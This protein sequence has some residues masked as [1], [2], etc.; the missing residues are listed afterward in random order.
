MFIVFEGQEAIVMK[1][2]A[3]K[4]SKRIKI[5]IVIA[6]VLLFFGI[7]YFC[8]YHSV[9]FHKITLKS[10]N[11][12]YSYQND[13]VNTGSNLVQI[14]DKLYYNYMNENILKSGLYEIS[15]DVTKRIDWGGISLLPAYATSV[16]T[17]YNGIILDDVLYSTESY[18]DDSDDNPFLYNYEVLCGDLIIK[19][20]D[21]ERNSFSDYLTIKN[22]DKIKLYQ[23]FSIVDDTIYLYSIDN[24]IYRYENNSLKKV[25]DAQ[26][27]NFHSVLMSYSSYINKNMIYYPNQ[28]N[29]IMSICR[30]DMN[31]QKVVDEFTIG[32]LPDCEDEIYNLIATNTYIY[33]TSGN[34]S[35][36]YR[37]NL[38][39]KKIEKIFNTDG[40]VTVNIIDNQPVLAVEKSNKDNG[41]YVVNSETSEFERICK[42]EAC[43]IYNLDDELIYFIDSERNLYRITSDGKNFEKIFG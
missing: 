8:F 4:K 31:T 37:I 19:K 14:G 1:K 2:D 28:D 38:K 42:K 21:V 30:Y 36:V 16:S 5:T 6:T 13:K 35:A 25:F 34:F 3:T 17:T 23:N 24:G 18:T 20:Y 33:F 7:A 10:T 40:V 9:S 26:K 29:D 41:I 43:F 32:N 15:A 27:L 11:V 39:T 12:N 22:P